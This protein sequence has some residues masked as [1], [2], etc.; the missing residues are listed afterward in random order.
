MK[1]LLVIYS[2][3][4]DKDKA[5]IKNLPKF[6]TNNNLRMVIPI[7]PAKGTIMISYTDNKYADYW[8]HL[9]KTKGI[10]KVNEKIAE[11]IKESTN[12]T[13]PKPV[14]TMVYYWS[15]GVGYWGI[16][17]DSYKISQK[18]IKPFEKEE[19]YICGEHY[20]EKN[21]QWIEGA[22]ETSISVLKKIY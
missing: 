18:I 19:V 3:F 7:N 15:C 1:V 16:G 11:N 21:Q 9:Y 8:N 5:W 17:A 14:E 20:S 13:I 2:K 22:L 12:I 6:T 10:E 4:N